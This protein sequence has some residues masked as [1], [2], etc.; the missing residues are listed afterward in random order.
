MKDEKLYVIHILESIQRVESYTAE[1]KEAFFKDT[2][3]QDA[4]LR[5]LH[6]M[7]ESTQ[8]LSSELKAKHPEVDWRSI[9]AFRNVLVHDYLGIN[10][11]R[12]WNIV[13]TVLPDFKRTVET[14]LEEMGGK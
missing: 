3:S 14:I 11:S 13:E 9:G 1:G 6:T 4:V 10:M 7:S 8:R 12:V 2:R 5:N